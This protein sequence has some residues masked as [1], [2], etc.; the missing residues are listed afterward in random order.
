LGKR[1]TLKTCRASKRGNRGGHHTKNDE[2]SA[3]DELDHSR[4]QALIF[5]GS[6]IPFDSN[7][8]NLKDINLLVSVESSTSFTKRQ[9][10][11]GRH[12]PTFNQ[13]FVE[14]ACENGQR[15][16]LPFSSWQA[17]NVIAQHT[18]PRI[19]EAI[20]QSKTARGQAACIPLDNCS[21]AL[22][23]RTHHDLATAVRQ[24]CQ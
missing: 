10:Q 5:P 4:I 15:C 1:F 22:H 9:A 17:G 8:V 24:T 2:R 21:P 16:V 3:N 7:A 14:G 12:C 11:A 20:Q 23:G 13:A 19:A 18:L 6:C